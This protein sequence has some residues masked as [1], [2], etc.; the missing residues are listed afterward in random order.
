MGGHKAPHLWPFMS[1]FNLS[2]Y[3]ELSQSLDRENPIDFEAIQDL[4]R[5]PLFFS[6]NT[7]CDEKQ[8]TLIDEIVGVR[9]VSIEK[10]LISRARN[11]CEISHSDNLGK[12]LHNGNQTWVGLDPNT[13]QTP[14]REISE[15]L[16]CVQP[17]KGQRIIDLGAAYGRMGMVLNCHYPDVE[18][19]GLEYVPERVSEG[20]RIYEFYGIDGPK[21][22]SKDLASESFD[23]EPADIYF[24]YEYGR[25]EHIQ[26]TLFEL[27]EIA[28][29]QKIILIARGRSCISL[30][31]YYHPW[32][33]DVFPVKRLETVSMYANF[34][35]F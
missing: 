19:Y 6:S 21:L 11:L 22:Y 34:K 30:I 5:D 24:I 9:A 8:S 12:S 31:D 17:K 29:N 16:D 25:K 20:N 7:S 14:Y 33:S 13:L 28:Q 26:K 10:E 32:L 1:G 3:Y 23:I 2:D 27:R 35:Y 15:V 18:F 4:L